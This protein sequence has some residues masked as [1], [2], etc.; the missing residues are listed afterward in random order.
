M[1]PCH[2]PPCPGGRSHRIPGLAEMHNG[3]G[4]S[5]L[6][7][8]ATSHTCLSAT[9]VI[10]A[11]FFLTQ[12]LLNYVFFFLN[13]RVKEYPTLK[14]LE[15]KVAKNDLF[16][17]RPDLLILLKIEIY[18]IEYCFNVLKLYIIYFK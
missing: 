9:L 7:L 10:S 13:K 8:I 1:T 14:C 5:L 11:C 2:Q 17:L 16:L 18:L 12:K 3:G 15:I 6:V 4:G